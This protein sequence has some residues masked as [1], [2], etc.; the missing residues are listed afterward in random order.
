MPSLIPHRLGG[1]VAPAFLIAGPGSFPGSPAIA[2]HLVVWTNTPP[3]RQA[4]R[5]PG[6]DIHGKDLSTGRLFRVTSLGTAAGRPAISG[7]VVVWVDC[8][9][10][11]TGHGLGYRETQIYGKDL[12]TGRTFPVAAQP[13]D[14]AAPAISGH[15]AVWQES[16]GD[17]ADIFGE[18]LSTGRLFPIALH[19][20]PSDVLQRPIVS[21]HW[22]VWVDWNGG[23]EPA[24]VAGKDLATGRRLPITMIP[25]GHFNPQFGPDVALS[26]HIVV[27]AAAK[28]ATF[29]S[30]NYDI[31]GMDLATGRR[32]P[33][34]SEP[35]DQILPAIS[36]TIVVWDDARGGRWAIQGAHLPLM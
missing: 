23:P 18:D 4:G 2:G 19:S 11:V 33:V 28:R 13:R 21:G 5:L 8:R 27:W 7:P 16:H 10:C 1:V 22:V 12:T 32:F 9:H 29:G 24:T 14:Q 20:G 15:I 26:G 3:G 31:Y 36:G 34:T 30:M 17:T 35:H 6:S 25:Y